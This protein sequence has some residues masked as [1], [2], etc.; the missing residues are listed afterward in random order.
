MGAEQRQVLGY[1]RLADLEAFLEVAHALH[2]LRKIFEYPDPYGVG[3]DLQ[4]FNALLSG[5]H[6][7]PRTVT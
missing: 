3:D 5:D 2:P 1:V 7:Q 4:D 6:G